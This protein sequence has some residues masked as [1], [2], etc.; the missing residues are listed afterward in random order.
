MARPRALGDNKGKLE[1]NDNW[2]N[3]NYKSKN[4]VTGEMISTK[5]SITKIILIFLTVFLSS[6]ARYENKLTPEQTISETEQAIEV[7]KTQPDWLDK[8]FICPTGIIPKNEKKIKYLNEGCENNPK[9]CLE[10]CK[11]EDGNACYSLALLIQDKINI[12]QKETLQLFYRS[13]RLGIV[14][15]CTN[16]AAT[17]FSLENKEDE[18]DGCLVDTFEKTCEHDDPWGCAMFSMFLIEGKGRPQDLDLA[19]KL[20]LK[21]CKYGLEDEACKNAKLLEQQISDIKNKKNK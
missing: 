13:C 17:K 14:S 9:R 10:G 18:P 6:C 15:G 16:Y 21:S 12:E 2:K 1:A 20:L 11:N 19:S 8:V 5:I 4:L 3:L 7:L